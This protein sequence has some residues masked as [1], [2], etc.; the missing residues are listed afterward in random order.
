MAEGNDLSK[1]NYT[2][3]NE[4]MLSSNSSEDQTAEI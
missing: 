4:N 2:A 3:K 1:S